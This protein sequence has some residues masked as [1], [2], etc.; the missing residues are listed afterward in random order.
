M[1]G[2]VRT[3]IA[4]KI[5]PKNEFFDLLSG[6]KE[7]LYGEDIKWVEKNNYHLTLHFLGD[8]TQEQVPEIQLALENLSQKFQQFQFNLK[9]IGYFK[10]KGQPRVLFANIE[11][12]L[13]LKQLAIEIEKQMVTIG[14][15]KEVREFKP[16]LTLGRIKF[17]KSKN[18][19]YSLVKKF[20]ETEIQKVVVSEIIFYQSI[21]NPSGPIYKSIKIVKLN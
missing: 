7:S 15:K 8:T 17:I 5:S 18:N 6:L 21:L 16:H 4:I 10:S 2:N 13:T 1:K 11:N 9:G 14:F 20:E 19:F 3:F 12:F